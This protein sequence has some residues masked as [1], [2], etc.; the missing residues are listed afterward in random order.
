MSQGSKARPIIMAASTA[1]LAVTGAWYGAG[2]KEKQEIK[3]V[4][5]FPLNVLKIPSIEPRNFPPGKRALADHV[6]WV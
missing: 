2:L 3:Q 5:S 4:Q 1:A 6:S